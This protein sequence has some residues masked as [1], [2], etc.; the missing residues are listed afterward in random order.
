VLALDGLLVAGVLT[1]TVLRGNGPLVTVVWI[2]WLVLF[3]RMIWKA[4]DWA[5]T[6]FVVTSHRMPL[7]SGVLFRK[8]AMMPLAK[9]TD[10]TFHRPFL[11]GETE[12]QAAHLQ[13]SVS[14]AY[15][16]PVH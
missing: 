14:L 3:A 11:M 8:V 10:M 13:C 7:T 2:V 1:A 12:R 9:V 5:V 15:R 4:I 16:W 6:F